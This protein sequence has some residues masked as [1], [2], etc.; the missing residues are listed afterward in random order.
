MAAKQPRPAC[1][2]ANL[3]LRLGLL[4]AILL[5]SLSGCL[6]TGTP[7][8]SKA[9]TEAASTMIVQLTLQSGLTAVAQLTAL[10]SQPSATPAPPT[11]L[12]PEPTIAA[13]PTP[14]PPSAT[15]LPSPTPPPLPSAT[16]QPCDRADFIADVSVPPGT[17]LPLGASFVKAWQIRNS[18]ACTWDRGYSLVFVDG[19]PMSGQTMVALP[20]SVAPGE[21]LELSLM[22]SV[23]TYPGSYQGFW[24]LRNPSG[25]IFGLGADGQ[26]SLEVRINAVTPNQSPNSNYDL[27]ADYCAAIWSSQ[28][29]HLACP[30]SPDDPNG[31]VLL[32]DRLDAENGRLRGLSLLTRTNQE[33][34]GWIRGVYPAY[35][36]QL[37]DH[38]MAQVGCL[39]DNQGCDI[40]F[41]LTYRT[42]DGSKGTLGTWREVYDGLATEI[43][44]DL[45]PLAGKTVEFA[46]I[47]YNAGK[48]RQGNGYWL[49]PRVT[50]QV[51]SA[52]MI[53]DWT[54]DNHQRASCAN[55]KLYIFSRNKATAQAY[56][57]DSQRRLGEVVLSPEDVSQVLEWYSRLSNF[58][59]EVFRAAPSNPASFYLYFSGAGSDTARDADIQAINSF[60]ARLFAQAAGE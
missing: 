53:L 4:A 23:P 14:L 50:R 21:T 34:N 25:T 42:T 60:A 36:V 58:D 44:I 52:N 7:D 40:T 45:T 8:T 30:G 27:A 43:D 18:G 3:C 55:L 35:R 38:F 26:Q 2:Q 19:T 17:S 22:L 56:T 12:P 13:S 1:V 15:P 48:P 6:A 28:A 11:P 37:D 39:A 31:S 10:A 57:C 24:K 33:R 29:S 41:Q 20:G 49:Q 59:A 16:P 32:Q 47:T 54:R 46:L 9:Y 5:W 51:L